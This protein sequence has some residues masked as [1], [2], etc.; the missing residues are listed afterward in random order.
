MYV[1]TIEYFIF[2]RCTYFFLHFYHWLPGSGYRNQITIWNRCVRTFIGEY[3]DGCEVYLRLPKRVDRVIIFR[4]GESIPFCYAENK[5]KYV[6]PGQ[7][8]KKR[9]NP[10]TFQKQLTRL[11][12]LR[13]GHKFLYW[14]VMFMTVKEHIFINYQLNVIQLFKIIDKY[15]CLWVCTFVSTICK[16]LIQFRNICLRFLVYDSCR[17]S[18]LPKS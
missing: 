14:Q 1:F 11:R 7:D 6:Y 13:K 5:G 9:D 4:F 18:I 12:N 16:I 3:M 17:L 8:L 15:F 2:H 10:F